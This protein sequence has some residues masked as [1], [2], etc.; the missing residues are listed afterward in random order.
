MLRRVHGRCVLISCVCVCLFFASLRACRLRAAGAGHL[1]VCDQPLRS[2]QPGHPFVGRCYEVTPWGVKAGVVR[3]WVAGKTVG[4]RCH[5]R[6]VSEHFRDI[7]PINNKALYRLSCL[8]LLMC[9][10]DGD[11]SGVQSHTGAAILGAT[12]R[13][14]IL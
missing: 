14:F 2:T 6:A 9:V 11:R 12:W 4:F 8:F 3:V 1:S 5:T 7:A 10:S 13:W